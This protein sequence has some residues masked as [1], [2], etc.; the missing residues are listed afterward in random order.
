M[1]RSVALHG[2]IVCTRRDP[3]R[4]RALDRRPPTPR[5]ES[6]ESEPVRRGADSY[7][8]RRAHVGV[9]PMFA[10]NKA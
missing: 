3:D 4:D 5:P 9:L 6:R 1:K 2:I 8:I 10:R 7:E